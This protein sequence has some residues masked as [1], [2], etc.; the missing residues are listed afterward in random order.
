MA[1]GQLGDD[2]WAANGSI[3]DPNGPVE[4]TAGASSVT[5]V[6]TLG[7]WTLM[8]LGLVLAGLGAGGLGRRKLQ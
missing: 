8:A 3:I 6:P 7:E 1:D 2:D 5:P 4:S